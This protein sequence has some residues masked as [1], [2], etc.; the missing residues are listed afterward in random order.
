MTQSAGRNAE[1]TLAVAGLGAIGM[2]VATAVGRGEVSGIRLTAVSARDRNRAEGRV[3]MFPSPPTV[4]SLADLAG[5]A[6]I[7]V[8]CA[9]AEVFAGVAGPAIERGR[10]FMPLSAGRS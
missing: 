4:V 6:D 9:P 1:M 2:K 3:A 5:L 10:I 7:I 8:E